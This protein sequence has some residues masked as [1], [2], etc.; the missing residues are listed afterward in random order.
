MCLGKNETD[1]SHFASSYCTRLHVS[2]V[3][4]SEPFLNNNYLWH[5]IYIYL[6]I[7][8]FT[9]CSP[10]IPCD[11]H[12]RRWEISRKP[13]H[14]RTVL[15]SANILHE[16][17]ICCHDPTL[18]FVNR[19]AK[20]LPQNSCGGKDL[21]HKSNLMLICYLLV[22]SSYRRFPHSD[23]TSAVSGLSSTY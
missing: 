11:I 17:F 15:T 9:K 6:S 3:Q 4:Y 14:S 16:F 21:T 10:S 20:L 18:Q 12:S 23:G 22:T 1:E 13:K 5:E 8:R 2:N 7:R 19:T